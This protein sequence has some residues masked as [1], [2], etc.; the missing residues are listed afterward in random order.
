MMV[1]NQYIFFLN[2]VKDNLLQ[3]LQHLILSIYLIVDYYVYYS[4]IIISILGTLFYQAFE[5]L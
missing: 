4:F 3:M 5:N 2:H 1:I